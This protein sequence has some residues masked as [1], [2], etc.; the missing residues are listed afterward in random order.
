LLEDRAS[1]MS[2][3][4]NPWWSKFSR[5][6]RIFLARLTCQL[7]ESLEAHAFSKGFGGGGWDEIVINIRNTRQAVRFTLNAVI[8]FLWVWKFVGIYWLELLRQAWINYTRNGRRPRGP[9]HR[10][11]G[12]SLSGLEITKDGH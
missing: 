10:K 11:A 1:E 12:H 4:C 2:S 5:I 3:H 7:T 6:H 9:G 8:V